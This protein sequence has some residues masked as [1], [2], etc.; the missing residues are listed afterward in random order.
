MMGAVI[1]ALMPIMSLVVQKAFPN[2]DTG[3]ASAARQCVRSI[4]GA[5]CSGGKYCTLECQ[6]PFIPSNILCILGS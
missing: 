3:V 6:Q 5:G 4:A 1:G 2:G